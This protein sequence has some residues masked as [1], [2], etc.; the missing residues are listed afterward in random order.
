[1]FHNNLKA[2]RLK[3][4]M[5]QKQIA[6]Y[7]C[8]SPQSVSKWEKGESLPSIEYLPK[9]A[10]CMNCD[11]NAFFAKD[12]KTV[13]DYHLIEA[14]FSLEADLLN[15]KI[16]F[17]RVTE[18]L[19]E[20]PDTFDVVTALCN[21]L[22]EYKTVTGKTIQRILNCNEA[23]AMVFIRYLERCEMLEKLDIVDA[24]YVMRDAVEGIIPLLKI[25]KKICDMTTE[26]K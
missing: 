24:Y 10:E 22:L 12:E 2:L 1:M 14:Y 11:M 3:S 18:F 6:D 13:F 16:E 4:G 15:E 23:E 25:H 9:L 5:S 21:E 26:L 8:V 17:N 20:N 7:I 19:I